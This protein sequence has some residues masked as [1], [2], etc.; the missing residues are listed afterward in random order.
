MH[1]DFSRQTFE[2][3]K[4]YAG[5]LLQQGRVQT[6]ADWNEAT[7][8]GQHQLETTAANVI[9]PTGAPRDNAGFQ[10]SAAGA[11]L[12]IGAG[13]YY[14]DG[15][16]CENEAA[17][18]LSAQTGAAPPAGAGLYAVYL[19]VWRRHVSAIEDP[20]IR[21]PALG[22]P[23]TATRV[24]TAWLVRLVRIGNANANAVCSTVSPQ[25]QATLPASTGTLRASTQ[26]VAAP[27]TPCVLPASAGYRGLENQLYRV[28]VHGAG[29]QATARFKWSRE[30]G[31]V[32]AAVE[33]VSG[34]DVTLRDLRT[35][36]PLGFAQG[37]WV[38]LIDDALEAA[39]QR[40]DLFQ[41]AQLAPEIRRVT[42]NTAPALVANAALHPR[43]RRWD[44]TAGATSQGVSMVPGGGATSISLE[45]GVE[46]SFGAGQYNAGDYWL[47][48]ARTALGNELG[49][50]DWPAGQFLPP[51]GIRHHFALLGAFNFDGAN[52]SATT[53]ADC[54]EIFP[55]L[56]DLHAVDVAYDAGACSDLAGV[57]TV[58]QALDVLCDRRE[59]CCGI[60]LEPLPGWEA[61]FDQIPAGG[62]G[63]FCFRAADYPLAAT[64][65]I[66][67]KGTILLTGAGPASRIVTNNECALLFSGCTS[68]TVRDVAFISGSPGKPVTG[69]KALN[70]VL[71]CDNVAA[72]TIEHV[73]ASCSAST[74]KKS[75]CLA[76]R[77]AAV[78]SATA[79]GPG[80]VRIRGCDIEVGYQQVGILVVNALRATI[81]DNA[82]RVGPDVPAGAQIHR[83]ITDPAVRAPIS[84]LLVKASVAKAA[85]SSVPAPVVTTAAGGAIT[86]RAGAQQVNF[87][88]DPSLAPAWSA[89]IAAAPPT[90]TTTAAAVAAYVSSLANRVLFDPTFREQFAL[91]RTW[92]DTLR[93]DNPPAAAQGIVVGGQVARDVRVRGNTL[94]GMIEGVHIGVSHREGQ[95]GTPDSAGTVLIRD[96]S[97]DTVLP[98]ATTRQ[99]YGIYLGNCD[100][101]VIEDNFIS[102]QRTVLTLRMHVDGIHI[103][104]RMGRRL[105]VRQNHLRGFQT[106]VAFTPTP[107]SL[108][109]SRLWVVAET[110]AESA[111]VAVTGPASLIQAN[112]IK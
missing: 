19:N 105:I 85:G 57:T 77:N 108:T 73:S 31:S 11:T 103:F 17:L 65:T 78:A 106:G 23:D 102:V 29:N 39:N 42:L 45:R 72:V 112:N 89:L 47:I 20:S 6:N 1:G 60:V 76:V 37:D 52:F 5:V 9:G 8:I 4:H 25:W 94:S 40:G 61:A 22:G 38:E 83:R 28:E 36:D 107:A 63:H 86:L 58:Q 95:R 97:I 35:D 88:T 33:S 46:V 48:P 55:P 81:E 34:A 44:Q 82:L 104:G 96:N 69:L 90:D 93:A 70:G 98:A 3:R 99:R 68:V 66:T 41:I 80:T 13:R 53:A 26:A 15:I 27:T 16:L 14:V 62:H 12:N 84:K 7:Q 18:A 56:T 54:R 51:A 64:K 100:S 92:F 67:G 91:L 32:V 111:S 2:P 10:L 21:E 101:A 87:S 79:A 110:M 49:T 43:L 30:N 109:A 75:A 59:E 50:I 71:T 24:Q 74:R